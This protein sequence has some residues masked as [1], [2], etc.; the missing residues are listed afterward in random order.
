MT[1]LDPRGATPGHRDIRES[2][3]VQV[4]K[5]G[6]GF[7]GYFVLSSGVTIASGN[8]DTGNTGDTSTLRG[9]NLI[10][11]DTSTD[12]EY[13]YDPDANNGR[14]T[15]WGILIRHQP[16]LENGT[17]TNKVMVPIL[18]Q[19]VARK[20]KLIGLDAQA[21]SQLAMRGIFMDDAP[22][23]A[24]ALVHPVSVSQKSA[25]YTVLVADNGT[26]FIS[27]NTG[28]Q[29]FTLPTIA[30]GLSYEFLQTINQE[31]LITSGDGDNIVLFNNSAADG[32]S[33]TTA[34]EQIGA[35]CRVLAVYI[36]TGSANLRWVVEQLSTSTLT[37]I[38]A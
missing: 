37:V 22:Q 23:G 34:G 12:N 35:R 16:M 2:G 11:T 1:F 19:G 15:A 38:D 8:T 25:D 18:S 36:G 13:I 5:A 3:E 7:P 27:T 28:D 31:M 26:L 32:I 29:E 21:E 33:Y 6:E 14:Q 10:A 20:S 24:A 17:A 4:Y 9:G 30:A